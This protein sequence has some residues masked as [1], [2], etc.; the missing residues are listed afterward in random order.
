V[1]IGIHT[2]IGLAGGDDY[3]GL[4]IHRAAR[5]AS[6]AHGGQTLVSDSTRALS[7]HDRPPGTSFI[8][9][10][11]H[12]LKDLA[13]AERIFEVGI[14]GLT[15]A[16]PPLR[17][18]IEAGNLQDRLTTFVGR[19]REL[20]E[21]EQLLGAA[22][23]VTIVGP[24]G[25]GKTSIGVELAR[26]AQAG[27]PDGS[28]LVRLDAVPDESRMA[29]AIA[30]ALGLVDGGSRSYWEQLRDHA[31]GRRLLLLLDNLE[32]VRGA[33]PA[34]LSFLEGAPGLRIVA[35]SR[36]P[37]HVAAEQIYQLEPLPLGNGA[38][39]AG[40]DA[41]NLFLDRARRVRPGYEPDPVERA[42]I[43]DICRHVD[44][45]PL[46]IELAA[47]RVRLLPVRTLA[48]RIERHLELPGPESA[49]APV[50][51]R[52]LTDAIAWSH[53][54]LEPPMRR[55]FARF[56]AFVDGCRLEEAEAVLGS[57]VPTG[58][59]VLGGVAELVDQSLVVPG[60][61][62][63]GPRFRMLETIRNFAA[64]RLIA[65]GELAAIRRGH[66]LAYL[67]LAE[68]Q[69]RYLPGR[70][71]PVRLARLTEDHA[72]LL[73][74]IA[75]AVETADADVALRFAAAMWRFWQLRGRT[76]E[77]WTLMPALLAVAGAERDD[78]LRMRALEAAGGIAYWRGD[79]TEA[80][81]NYE[82]QI[83]IAQ[84]IGDRAGEADG[85][86]NLAHIRS[87]G[88]LG[89]D[90]GPLDR[91]AALYVELGDERGMA[92][93]QWGRAQRR[94]LERRVD[95]LE[96]LDDLRRRFEVLD[97]ALYVQLTT[98][99]A[100]WVSLSLG[101]VEE[102][103]RW[104]AR[105]LRICWESGDWAT[106]TFDLRAAAAVT[107]ARNRIADAAILLA[108]A[109]ELGRSFGIRPPVALESL[110]SDR[111]LGERLGARLSSPD[112]DVAIAVGSA[113]SL[114]EAVDFALRTLVPGQD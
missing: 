51:Q 113:M 41:V 36:S 17:T 94:F 88:I 76:D 1:R 54:L 105:S 52:S 37:L 20:R 15:P 14:D 82:A 62:I 26:R 60:A 25:V 32:Q 97:D 42:A 75:W 44:G 86:F 10:G 92:R 93:V 4:D 114:D 30:D 2:G 11:A 31:V 84:T 18:L 80:A 65:S 58:A 55:L 81:R 101:L 35:T 45:L 107:T 50:R 61:G 87:E 69:A 108:A 83:R 72:N 16:F 91:S 67:D 27:H 38:S 110:I 71:Q 47:A 21:L 12:R 64:D 103:A 63:D 57:D 29:A 19:A 78:H 49:E 46:G 40:S 112:H 28:W 70:G 90:S 106:A 39:S 79:R 6:V 53:D 48:A 104:A 23:L 5:I 89:L 56:S 98:G 95:T 96:E 33:G 43:A 3:V 7:V 22:R 68:S 24:G 102:A 9:L 100:S 77:G 111:P 99:A 8:D 109:D 59:D 66:A 34:L 13:V 73:A 74:A 85:W